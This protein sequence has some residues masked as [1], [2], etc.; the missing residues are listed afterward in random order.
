MPDS[1]VGPERQ[2]RS[3]IGKNAV[4][5]IIL[6]VVSALIGFA[7]AEV[8][9]R[10]KNSSG[11]NYDIEMW[12]YANELKTPSENPVLGH[13]HVPSTVAVLQSTE[14]RI[15]AWGL[16]GGPV[17]PI[18]PGQRRILLLGS[19]ITMGWGV[20]EDEA[21]A[22]RLEALFRRDGETVQVLNAGIGN[23][24][25]VRYVERF[26][27]KLKDLRPTDIVLHYFINDAET[28]EA[29]GGN[30]LLRNSQLAVTLWT[31]ANRFL[32]ETGE[33]GLV[34]HYRRVYESGAKGYEAMLSALDRIKAYA[35]TAG[36]R[37]Y[38]AVVPDVHNLIDYPFEFI[39][40]R[41]AA[42]A[43][44][45]GFIFVDQLPDFRGL[46]PSEVWSLPGDPHPNSLGH[47]RMAGSLYRAMVE[48]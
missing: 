25:T 34:G 7:V 13:E 28:L 10:I 32:G 30:M 42:V 22:A 16:R 37:V 23:Y 8:F 43:A 14:I 27:T 29:G 2:A 17:P 4:Y 1:S 18:V 24:N 12:R 15:N 31:A 5:T 40:E 39:H 36:I 33:T 41:M 9:V 35:E 20:P 45:R 46:T 48:K 19:S 47:A 26:L 3:K 6:L 11:T 44:E 21:L 38:L